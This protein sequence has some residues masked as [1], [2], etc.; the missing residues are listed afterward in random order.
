MI[1]DRI[2]ALLTKIPGARGLWRRFPFGSVET[3]VR[4]GVF[5]RPHY[6]Y[7]VYAAADLARRLGLNTISAIELGVAGG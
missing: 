2:L 1:P 3:R 5:D 7:G 6:A 4:Y